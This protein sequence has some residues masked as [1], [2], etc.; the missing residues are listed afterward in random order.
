MRHGKTDMNEAGIIQG[1]LDAALTPEGQRTVELHAEHLAA[2]SL[3]GWRLLS[4]PMK[5]TRDSAAI[6]QGRLQVPVE[7]V[8]GL[9]E[10]GRGALE[11]HAKKSLPPELAEAYRSF[12]A[13]PWSVR[14]PGAGA[15][16]FADVE[17]RLAST[18]VPRIQALA[19]QPGPLAVVTHGSVGKI[20]VKLLCGLDRPFLARIPSKHHYLH[21]V[22][23]LDGRG[24]LEVLDGSAGYVPLPWRELPASERP[25][26]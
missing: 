7:I 21:H 22:R 14:P 15:E 3:R 4:G 19:G 6:L 24:D 5:R 11:G 18:V 17:Q 26:A 10:I 25:E 13:D 1:G 8:D 16:S 12:Q 20:L 2:T 23:L 9:R